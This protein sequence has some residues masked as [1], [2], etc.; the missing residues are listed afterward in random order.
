[1][2]RCDRLFYDGYLVKS[3]DDD[4]CIWDI[5]DNPLAYGSYLVSRVLAWIVIMGIGYAIVY[6]VVFIRQFSD[7]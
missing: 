6:T 3:F 5:C 1:M 2:I 7:L 4:V